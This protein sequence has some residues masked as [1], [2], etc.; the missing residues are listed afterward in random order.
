M[1]AALP[2]YSIA[3]VAQSGTEIIWEIQLVRV[4]RDALVSVSPTFTPINA[5]PGVDPVKLEASAAGMAAGDSYDK[6]GAWAQITGG[7][8]NQK[9]HKGASGFKSNTNRAL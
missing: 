6:F 8:A 1:Y 3:E 2:M 4:F 7:V 5:T 9:A